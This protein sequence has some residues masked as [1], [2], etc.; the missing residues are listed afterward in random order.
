MDGWTGPARFY[1]QR[2]LSHSERT[3]DSGNGDSEW[4]ASQSSRDQLRT[5][6]NLFHPYSKLALKLKLNKRDSRQFSIHRLL[7][8]SAVGIFNKR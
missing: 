1:I 5:I 4:W 7:F 3:N 8:W 6:Y 2:S